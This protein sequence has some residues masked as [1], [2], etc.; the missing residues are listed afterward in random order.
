MSDD[1]DGPG[2]VERAMGLET[3]ASRS[4]GIGGRLKQ[5]PS[6]FRV[7]EISRYPLPDPQGHWTIL[8]VE[9]HDVE[10]NELLRR[11]QREFSLP[12]GSLGIAGT[13]DRRA[14]TTQLVSLPGAPRGIGPVYLNGIR[15]LEAYRA[16]H[17]LSLGQL[18][19]NRFRIRV[20]EVALAPAEIAARV[21]AVEKELR[22]FGGFPNFFG[23]QRFGEV[24][25]VTH[26][27]GRELVRG[28]VSTAVETYLTEQALGESP[29]GAEARKLYAAHH[30]PRRALEEFPRHLGPERILLDRLARGD[31]PER[32]FRALPRHLR[33]LFVHAYQSF[34]FNRALSRR[35]LRGIPVGE[36]LPGDRLVRL[37]PDGL[38]ASLP[39][40]P[41]GSGNLGEARELVAAGRARVGFPLVGT[42]SG[43]PEG[44]PGEIVK[45][46]LEEERVRPRDFHIPEAP[47]L[48]SRGTYRA[49]RAP[50]PLKILGEP[51]VEPAGPEGN[52]VLFAFALEKGQYATVLLREFRK[53][54]PRA[55]P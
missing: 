32:A 34:L 2:P 26:L 31:P 44:I 47:D 50:L 24:R 27:V 14:L 28:S 52:R 10:Q 51:P 4:P 16:S 48:S 5:E 23:P 54:G 9:S 11:L 49:L 37:A 33:I 17:P 6:D 42:E 38:D 43:L 19:G 55:F 29:D 36:P 7:D 46:V 13:K 53:G 15:I 45:G 21:A 22:T 3:Y 18:Y 20:V 12:P 30:D 41:V 1:P 8:R 40:I 39:P 35:M 25:P